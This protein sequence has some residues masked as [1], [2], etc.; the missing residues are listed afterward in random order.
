MKT[1]RASITCAIAQALVLCLAVETARADVSD[2]WITIKT[3]ISLLTT[4]GLR[5]SEI[6]VDTI[7]G[8][9]TLHGKVS[10]E[11]EREKA[12][13]IARTIDG[14]SEVRNLLQVVPETRR[15]DVAEHDEVVEKRVRE[16]LQTAPELQHSGIDVVSVNDGVV[17]LGGNAPDLSTQLQ[18]IVT[19]SHVRG[20]REVRTNI[21]GP[22]E[23]EE[24]EIDE[25]DQLMHDA[26][27]EASGATRTVE[28]AIKAA[29]HTVASVTRDA[30]ITTAT[31]AGLLADAD[32]PGLDV[33]VDTR[34]GVVTLFGIVPSQ[35]ARAQATRAA[36]RVAGVRGV[37][38]SLEVVPTVTR[39]HVQLEDDAAERRVIRALCA[40]CRT[41]CRSGSD[42][43]DR[44]SL[45]L[46]FLRGRG[47]AM[48]TGR[49]RRSP[50]GHT[51]HAVP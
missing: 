4:E 9:V 42:T 8:R 5:A 13:A 3:K 34:D 19:T 15:E 32:V 46:P 30:W 12:A 18:A 28:T 14:T 25:L 47:G 20:V 43:R 50:A 51:G 37:R 22:S 49:P 2:P 39:E 44:G 10:S 45:A 38:N 40:T 24:G 33:G 27:P 11:A 29:G 41:S 21:E 35:A 16:A 36:A 1:R 23:L 6:D 17:L 7:D 48:I 26:R 31:K